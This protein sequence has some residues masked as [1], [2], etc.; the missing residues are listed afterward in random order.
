MFFV[1]NILLEDGQIESGQFELNPTSEEGQAVCRVFAEFLK[2]RPAAF[3]DKIGF[4]N[5]GDFELDWSAADG[6]VALASLVESGETLAMGVLLTGVQGE[7]DRRMLEMFV[8]NVLVPLFGNVP[9]DEVNKLAQVSERPLLLQ[10]LFPGSP[11]W[12]PAVQL[13]STALA[14][15]YFKTILALAKNPESI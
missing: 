13:L 7:S 6:G 4:M 15:V 3:R 12:A 10:L 11:E 1:H 14:S 2:N 9:E 8:A 5:R